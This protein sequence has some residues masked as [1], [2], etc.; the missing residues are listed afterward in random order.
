MK[1]VRFAPM[2]ALALAA[3]GQVGAIGIP[4]GGGTTSTTA[5]GQPTDFNQAAPTT[6]VE[7]G[8]LPPPAGYDP[9]PVAPTGTAPAGTPPVTTTPDTLAAANAIG[10]PGQAGVLAA[11]GNVAVSATDLLGGWTVTAGSDTCQLFMT[12]TAWTGGY[13]ASTRDC[14]SSVLQSISAWSVEGSRVT[15][16]SADGTAI[17][18]LGAVTATRFEGQV[19]AGGLPIVFFR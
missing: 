19:I 14:S 12:L 16:A 5:T 10:E 9:G 18:T 15:L 4:L 11:T 7:T 1:L 17:A 2:M 8:Q 3:C 6:A 13:R